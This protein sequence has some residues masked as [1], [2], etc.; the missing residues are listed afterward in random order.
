MC[1]LWSLWN[2]AS[3]PEWLSLWSVVS[4]PQWVGVV[5]TVAAL[6]GAA[7][8]LGRTPPRRAGKAASAPSFWRS[9]A[10]AGT[11]T[12]A[13]L[14]IGS[15]WV[16]ARLASPLDDMVASLHT[17]RLSAADATLLSAS[18]YE[19]LIVANRVTSPLLAAMERPADWVPIAETPAMRKTGDFLWEELVPS[20][21]I[22][23]KEAPLRINRW[24]FRD[25]EYEKHPP[26]GT[27]RTAVLGSSITMGSGVSNDE[28][29]EALLEERLNGARRGAGAPR[30]EL[31]NFGVPGRSLLQH[32]YV[33][34]KQVL[35]FE[36]D[37][38][39]LVAHANEPYFALR[40]LAKVVQNGIE[41][42]YAFLEDL[43]REAGVD[44]QGSMPEITRQL[45]PFIPEIISWGYRSIALSALE[46]GITPVWV[47]LPMARESWTEQQLAAQIRTAREAGFEIWDLSNAYEGHDPGSLLIAEWDKHPNAMGHRLIADRLFTS[48]REHAWGPPRGVHKR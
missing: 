3:V 15:P 37:A 7:V 9:V 11:G 6:S 47:Y 40:H 48:F 36:P 33:L 34:E 19:N 13:L 28:T 44:S 41:N 18:Y 12:L 31:L 14:F 42:P 39:L 16:Y 20:T 24:G 43:M 23:F 29:F 21:E 30:Y 35:S 25:K 10:T 1:V 46:H 5:L 45:T 22:R 32:V 2:S 4:T 8:L 17:A 38:I 27:F 26:P